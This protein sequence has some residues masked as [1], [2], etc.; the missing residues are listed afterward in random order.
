MI[1]S[2]SLCTVPFTS[3][4]STFSSQLGA[5]PMKIKIIECR[6]SK[7]L[8]KCRQEREREAMWG[9]VE[10]LVLK[11]IYGHR[12]AGNGKR[13]VATDWQHCNTAHFCAG[14]HLE[15]QPEA[16]VRECR[17][18]CSTTSGQLGPRRRRGDTSLWSRELETGQKN[19]Q[20]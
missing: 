3:S 19:R 20:G 14:G 9:K 11:I 16:Q 18:A 13:V 7:E 4:P 2:L 1:Y 8:L 5:A 15:T 12:A 17:F 6:F 10:K